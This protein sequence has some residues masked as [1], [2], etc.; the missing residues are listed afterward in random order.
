VQSLQAKLKSKERELDDVRVSAEQTLAQYQRRH[1]DE[2]DLFETGRRDMQSQLEQAALQ[3]RSLQNELT[4]ATEKQRETL[5]QL[6][7][8]VRLV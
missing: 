4:D 1:R 8:Q 5:S 6:D 7:S 2:V 3:R